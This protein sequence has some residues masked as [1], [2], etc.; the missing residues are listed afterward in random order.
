MVTEEEIA[1][2]GYVLSFY[3]DIENLTNSYA[4]YINV[5]IRMKDKYKLN[6]GIKPSGADKVKLDVED[7]EALLSVAETL[8]I[9]I[10]RSYIKMASLKDKV[11]DMEESFKGVKSL[12]EK[13]L[14]TS[15]IEKKVAEEY[16]LKINQSF[17][18]GILKELLIRSKDIYSE[19]LKE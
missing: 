4:T 10:T 14:S 11:S 3:N 16:V 18:T 1:G 8:R 6:E 7:E 2:S 19:F 17:V 12:Y 15:I 5:L 9:W 13:S